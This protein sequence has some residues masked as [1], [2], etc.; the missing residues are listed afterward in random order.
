MIEGMYAICIFYKLENKIFLIRDRAGEKPL[1]Y[2]SQNNIFLFGSEL[3]A[4]LQS[5]F[6]KKK[7]DLSSIDS[8]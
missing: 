5:K 1:Y 6:F 2:S 4:L 3:K 8:F 7:L